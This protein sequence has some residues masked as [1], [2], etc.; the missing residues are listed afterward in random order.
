MPAGSSDPGIWRKPLHFVPRF[1][2]HVMP[3]QTALLY[4]R[5]CRSRGCRQLPSVPL[6]SPCHN[7]LGKSLGQQCSHFSAFPFN[8]HWK[9]ELGRSISV[10]Q[11]E[12]NAALVIP[13]AESKKRLT[14]RRSA[15]CPPHVPILLQG[16]DDHQ[17]QTC[18]G[19]QRTPG[20][21]GRAHLATALRPRPAVMPS[22][23]VSRF[24]RAAD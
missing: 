5:C 3:L 6:I 15:V 4:E 17:A 22:W 1:Q 19:C 10:H 7:F 14:P 11:P 24:S 13:G 21:T 18:G 12:A 8:R 16:A 2:P 23:A 20:G 9:K